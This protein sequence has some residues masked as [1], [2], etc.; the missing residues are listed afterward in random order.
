MGY[1]QGFQSACVIEHLTDL[2]GEGRDNGRIK[3]GIQSCEDHAANYNADDDF[4]T[5]IDISLGGIAGDHCLGTD[6]EFVALLLNLVE[7]LF[8][9]V[10]SLSFFEF[11]ICF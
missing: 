3:Q 8:H 10:F 2:G 1:R 7:N 5:R 11:Q 9:V 4:D 6:D